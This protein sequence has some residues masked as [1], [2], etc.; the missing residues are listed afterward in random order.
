MFQLL[1]ECYEPSSPLAGVLCF[2]MEA[3]RE[4]Q[5]SRHSQ[6]QFPAARP[7]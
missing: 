4:T 7:T 6:D 3:A 5:L 2:D 1:N